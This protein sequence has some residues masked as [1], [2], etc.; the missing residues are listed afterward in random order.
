MSAGTPS[1]EVTRDGD[2]FR[3]TFRTERGEGSHL[4]DTAL[5]ALAFADNVAAPGV[6][7]VGKGVLS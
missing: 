7:T 4:F 6:V 2:R 3:V 1:A 5:Q